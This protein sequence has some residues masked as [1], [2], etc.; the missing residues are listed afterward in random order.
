MSWLIEEGETVVE[1]RQGPRT[2]SEPTKDFRDMILD[3]RIVH[4]SNPL[5]AWAVSNAVVD[6][7]DR[8]MNIV[9]N[10]SKSSDRIDPL[11]AG[12]NSHVRA[13]HSELES[14][15]QIFIV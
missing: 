5:F 12:I 3:M 10:K 8:N 1:I 7:V 4:N 6:V 9:L 14:E 15:P 13:M 2:L 11:S